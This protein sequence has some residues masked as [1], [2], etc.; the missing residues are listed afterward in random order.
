MS[1]F[2]NFMR[3]FFD[4]QRCYCNW[5]HFCER[6]QIVLLFLENY[7]SFHVHCRFSWH[8]YFLLFETSMN[9]TQIM[10]SYFGL[11]F[12]SPNNLGVQLSCF[13]RRKKWKFPFLSFPPFYSYFGSEIHH[14]HRKRCNSFILWRTITGHKKTWC[15]TRNL[16]HRNRSD[17]LSYTFTIHQAHQNTSSSK[18]FSFYSFRNTFLE[19]RWN[20]ILPI[21]KII[22]SFLLVVNYFKCWK[23]VACAF[24]EAREIQLQRCFWEI[25]FQR[26]FESVQKIYLKLIFG[27]ASK[28]IP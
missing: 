3:I 27:C 15:V 21:Q 2:K 24:F 12:F 13:L 9:F 19:D 18:E 14:E 25:Q 8:R 10:R 5:I 16:Q 20:K 7:E 11:D 28:K 6:Y 1:Q 22:C 23:N 4:V 26:H 17:V